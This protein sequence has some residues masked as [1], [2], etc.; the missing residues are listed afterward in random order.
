[1]HALRFVVDKHHLYILFGLA[2]LL[3]SWVWLGM[4]WH[5]VYSILSS[6]PI[7]FLGIHS[8]SIMHQYHPPPHSVP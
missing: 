1:M 8:L 6:S 2:G 3:D 4:G 7:G 5:G